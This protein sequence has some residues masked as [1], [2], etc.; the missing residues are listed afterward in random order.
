MK[1][2]K[3]FTLLFTVLIISIVLSLGLSVSSIVLNQIELS[4]TGRESQLAFY[5]AD[6]GGE[7]A[8]YWDVKQNAFATSTA[9]T[10]NCAGSSFTVGGASGRSSFVLNFDNGSCAKVTV[11]KNP[12]NTVIESL[13][14]DRTGSQSDC[15]G[16]RRST[17]RGIRLTL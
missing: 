7:C 8:L 9:S 11:D 6:A 3:G 17:E 2:K 14:R 4:G 12:E 1:M 15:S 13:G 5:A 16:I 10:I